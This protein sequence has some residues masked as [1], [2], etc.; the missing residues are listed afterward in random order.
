MG[1]FIFNNRFEIVKQSSG[2]NSVY[3]IIEWRKWKKIVGV[4]LFYIIKIY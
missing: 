3:I 4:M 2:F 1:P